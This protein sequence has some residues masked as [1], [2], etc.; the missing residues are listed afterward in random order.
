MKEQELSLEVDAH[1]DTEGTSS[2]L[3][4]PT[5]TLIKWCSK[6]KVRIPYVRIGRHSKY[7]ATGLKAYIEK[8]TVK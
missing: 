3:S 2:L 4:I 1:T 8:S 5:A 6:G 7:R